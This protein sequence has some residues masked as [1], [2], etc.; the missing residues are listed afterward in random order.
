[1][2][3]KELSLK[4]YSS[5][6]VQDR[7]PLN[8]PNIQRARQAP[9]DL[10]EFFK[11][12]FQQT[13]FLFANK[14]HLLYLCTLNVASHII[15]VLN[16]II[17]KQKLFVWLSPPLM[18]ISRS[19]LLL[20]LRSSIL[21]VRWRGGRRWRSHWCEDGSLEA[22]AETLAVTSLQTSRGWQL[23]TCKPTPK[24]NFEKKQEKENELPQRKPLGRCD[25]PLCLHGVH[26]RTKSCGGRLC[27]YYSFWFS[28][29]P[30][31]LTVFVSYL[32][33][34]KNIISVEE[35]QLIIEIWTW[36]F[37]STDPV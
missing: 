30:S 29:F 25:L 17:K 34:K 7:V 6:Q 16:W 36:Y 9:F 1:M 31:C 11:I 15:T 35:M 12:W 4:S 10:W 19:A 24:G 26:R 28:L 33:K 8:L 21:A 32:N 14:W 2:E 20:H 13:N 18:I 5:F 27:L 3:A 22:A 37:F 23:C